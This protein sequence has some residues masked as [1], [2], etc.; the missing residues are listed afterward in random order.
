MPYS[1]KFEEFSKKENSFLL[2]VERD[3]SVLPKKFP[4][5]RYLS[6][7]IRIFI[8]YIDNSSMENKYLLED[9]SFVKYELDPSYRDS[10][11]LAENPQNNFEIRVWTYGYY[12]IQATI[13]P[14]YGSSY[15]LKGNVFFPVSAKEREENSI[16]PNK[17][18]KKEKLH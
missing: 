7:F 5:H 6:F 4:N 17:D 10:N 2:K 14:K 15:I 18:S 13:F 11:R 12:P 16:E 1:Q 8:D 3:A 9:I